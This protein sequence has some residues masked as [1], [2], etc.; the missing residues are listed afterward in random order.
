MLASCT[1]VVERCDARP[2]MRRAS[3]GYDTASLQ[4]C[5][6]LQ[7]AIALH[8]DLFGKCIGGIKIVW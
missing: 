2:E 7:A 4:R 8:L 6:V 5:C 1:T 3:A